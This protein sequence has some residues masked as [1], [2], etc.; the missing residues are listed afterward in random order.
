MKRD[1]SLYSR[2]RVE[3]SLELERVVYTR[4]EC[5][6]SL[7]RESLPACCFCCS[8]STE[9]P[10]RG[11]SAPC[12]LC[13]AHRPRQEV[14]W[15]KKQNPTTIHDLKTLS[16]YRT[17][18]TERTENAQPVGPQEIELSLEK[19]SDSTSDDCCWPRG[20]LARREKWMNSSC[21]M[22]AMMRRS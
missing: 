21:S 22:M 10:R 13:A 17:L 12:T 14:L 19:Q 6:I 2:E 8:V 5:R 3:R 18:V 11:A 7:E 9:I 1:S 4:R 20:R 16:V 15:F